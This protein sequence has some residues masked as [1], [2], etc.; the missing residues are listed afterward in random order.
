MSTRNAPGLIRRACS[1]CGAEVSVGD[2]RLAELGAKVLASVVEYETYNDGLAVVGFAAVRAARSLGLL[3][4][5]EDP[6]G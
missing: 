6:P 1:H 2:V 5:P 3:P 4:T